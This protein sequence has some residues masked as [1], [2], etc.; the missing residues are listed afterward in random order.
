MN[1]LSIEDLKKQRRWIMWRLIPV[2]GRETKVPYHPDGYKASVKDSTAWLT[3]AEADARRSGF[4]GVGLVLGSID[5]VSIFGV[6]IDKCCEADTGRFSPETREVVIELDTYSEY[7][8]SGT[9]C[10]I[11]G[12]GDLGDRSGNKFHHPGC[13]EIEIYDHDRFLTFTGRYIT[14]TPASLVDRKAAVRS[15]HDRLAVSQPRRAGIIVKMHVSEEDRLR[16]LLAGDMSDY[17][18]DH[19]RADLALC[20][21]LAKKYACNASKIDAAF[22]ASE[23][24]RDKWEREDYREGTITKAVINVA[25][26]SAV[27]MPDSNDRMDEDAPTEYLIDTLPGPGHEGWFP[28]GEISLIGGSSGTGKTNWLL[29]VLE[30]V[31]I[32]GE[33]FG[34]STKPREY[35]ILT[36]DRSRSALTKTA[37]AAGLDVGK[38]ALEPTPAQRRQPVADVLESHI[39][40]S[41]GIEAWVIEGLDMTV[42]NVNDLEQVSEL[43]ESLRTVAARHRVAV[44]GTL[45]SAKQKQGEGYLQHRDSLYG[46]IAFGRK[47]ETVVTLALHD[48]A[49]PNSARR[50]T[51]LVRCGKTEEF[52]FEFRAGEGLCITA[53]PQPVRK[54]TAFTRIEDAVFGTYKAGEEI[55]YQSPFGSPATFYRWRKEAAAEGRIVLNN[56]RFFVPYVRP[57]DTCPMCK[58]AA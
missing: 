14:K 43:M 52:F 50:C 39:L 1:S 36:I 13:K 9:G 35:R 4:S 10:H 17:A 26:E 33:V 31:R 28:L 44:V 34:H 20:F 29:R 38:R 21:L 32:G 53:E 15:L 7:S 46:S 3:Y 22:R 57:G 12:L 41:P 8:P 16:K 25:R 19:S 49:N 37:R 18:E 40:G 24:Y 45:G 58:Q 23:L 48:P 47:A 42:K 55:E 27:V 6:D 11:V 54:D 5:G 56:K 30:N 51:V 2:N